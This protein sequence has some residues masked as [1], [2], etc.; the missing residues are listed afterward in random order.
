[1]MGPWRQFLQSDCTTARRCK[2]IL[3][4]STL[5]GD[6]AV[7]AGS[8]PGRPLVRRGGGGKARN[9]TGRRR[10]TTSYD[11]G[12]PH[13]AEKRLEGGS[14]V[15]WP[16]RWCRQK[17]SGC[18][19]I[20]RW[21]WT[22]ASGN[23]DELSATPQAVAGPAGPPQSSTRLHYAPGGSRTSHAGADQSPALP[24]SLLRSTICPT[25]S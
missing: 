5:H 2:A 18:G 23:F 10:P 22:S 8:S 7:F 19:W 1:M 6:H 20:G 14:R 24:R 4:A 3:D 9:A 12:V 11:D 16:R 15:A 21:R 13:A 25:Q 17:V